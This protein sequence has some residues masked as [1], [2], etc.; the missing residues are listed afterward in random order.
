[1]DYQKDL[2]Q[3]GSTSQPNFHLS[4][5]SEKDQMTFK[6]SDNTTMKN[7]N[8]ER[9]KEMADIFC[10]C[11]LRWDFVFQRPQHL[12]TRFAKQQRV[13]YFEEPQF[14]DVENPYLREVKD[15]TGVV[16]LT[17]FLPHHK[18][19]PERNAML[20]SLLEEIFNKYNIVKY[21]CWYYT[22]MSLPFS[23]HLQPE[24]TVY[25]CMDE[26]SAFKFAPPS[27]L[28]LEEELMGKAQVMFTGGMNLYEHKKAKHKNVHGIP[29]SVDRKHFESGLSQ[30]DPEDL[31]T[32]A[33]PRVGFFGVI[34]ERM[35]L[36]L[37]EGLARELPDWNLVIIGPV[38]KIDPATLP[39]LSNI[40]YLGGKTYQQLP[41]YLGNWDVAMLP[42][43]LNESTRFISPT[44]TP[45]YLSAGKPVV[46]TPIKD[47]VNPYGDLDLV[48]IAEDAPAFA[49]AVKKAFDQKNDSNWRQATDNFL[50]QNSWDI[51]W[52][53]MNGLIN[54]A[55]IKKNSGPS[56]YSSSGNSA[57]HGNNTG[58]DSARKVQGSVSS[59]KAEFLNEN[60]LDKISQ[61]V[62]VT[63][64]LMFD[65]LIVGAGFAG[66]VLAERLANDG[67]K[68][69]IID[70]R[71]HIGGNAYDC[72][73][74]DG[75]LIHKYGPHI[76][77]TNSLEVFDYLGKFTKWRS[78]EHRVLASVDGSLVPLPINLD[79][80]NRLYGYNFN[81]TQVEE[82]F[83]SIAEPKERLLTSEDVV[84]SKVGRDLYEKFFK[85]YTN[86]QWGMDP[87]ELNAS[88]TARVPTRTNRDDRYFTDTY[89][90]MPLNGYTKMFQN[91][92]SHPNIKIM[93]NTDYKEITDLIPFREMVYSGPI[94]EFFNFRYGKLPYRS[95][96]FVFETHDAN[97]FQKTGTV[98]YPNEQLYTRISE[99]KYMTGQVH[100]KTSV[101]YEYPK[102]EGDPYYPVPKKENADLYNRYEKLALQERPD[103]HFVGRLATYKYYNMDQVVAQALSVYKKIKKAQQGQ[104]EELS[105]VK[106]ERMSSN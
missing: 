46:S 75:L 101:V 70:K 44:K 29:S 6:H 68:V 73:N 88:V 49:A 43:A 15:D 102:A 96:D 3:S 41:A 60:T 18:S 97:F 52:T 10:F 35:D 17:P 20:V 61:S 62:K 100:P 106:S 25:D 94:D 58:N 31:K 66:S 34:D 71:N 55:I 89:Q 51:T 42:F 39:G 21:I 87:S 28:E 78:Y 74:D 5:H 40:H 54:D 92:L 95:L 57:L 85:G 7:S 53:K 23:R 45:E 99:F 47:V 2:H 36:G 79:T 14:E 77:H 22:P 90:A 56:G 59:L 86:K 38:V 76:F 1:M 32:I 30:A 98:N 26:L 65:Y 33:H 27:L 9:N 48:H 16:I 8:Q 63:R 19:E 50:S 72:Y 105:G 67:K 12:L 4:Q 37:L 104:S 11:H 64:T 81:V 13:F 103:V 82:Y 69:L 84:V 91:M 24:I 93:L 83:N 80:I